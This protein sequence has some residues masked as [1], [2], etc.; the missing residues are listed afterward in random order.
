MASDVNTNWGE[1]YDSAQQQLEQV[2]AQIDQLKQQAASTNE[3]A[4]AAARAEYSQIAA[5]R[6]AERT[7]IQTELSRVRSVQLTL[8]VETIPNTK[9]TRAEVDAAKQAAAADPNNSSLQKKAADLEAKRSAAIAPLLQQLEQATAQ[10]NALEIQRNQIDQKYNAQ[11]TAAS[12]KVEAARA[13]N[14]SQAAQLNSLLSQRAQLEAQ[15]QEA[16][17]R[18]GTQDDGTNPSN[19]NTVSATAVP[20]SATPGDPNVASTTDPSV[21]K[22]V[23]APPVVD[24]QGNPTASSDPSVNTLLK[25]PPIAGVDQANLQA[26]LNQLTANAQANVA[27]ALA[28]PPALG[29]SANIGTAAG[30]AIAQDQAQLQSR[31]DW[32]VR[33]ALADGVKYLY[34]ADNPGILEPLSAKKGTN[35]VIFPYTPTISVAYAAQYDPTNV[36]HSNYTVYQ[37]SYSKVDQVT[38]TCSFTAQD[39]AEAKYMLAVAHFFRSMTKMFYGQDADPLNGT[40]PPLCYLFGMGGWQFDGLP[41]AITG[42][43][44][45]LPE[46]VDYIKTAT[47][48]PPNAPAPPVASKNSSNNRLGNKAE[49]GGTPAKPT[50]PQTPQQTQPI[51][52]VPTRMQ[53]SVSC[54]PMMSRNQTSNYFSLKDYA[55]GKLL[56]GTKRKG[57]AFW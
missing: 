7:P 54:L 49:P 55:N 17:N 48:A 38:I 47:P 3:A 56:E 5:Q 10:V 15:A 43:N 23:D 39:I 31:A 41:L 19:T 57:G 9:P 18:L 28:Q 46:D 29:L 1:V 34:N 22:L 33:L 40:P 20:A 16:F 44:Y 26:G 13:G 2:N 12:Q 4:I 21:Q 53:M 8:Q 11:L 42:F 36:A 27:T 35:G 50:Y 37:Y 25:A 30:T 24:A 14:E 32:R 6:D 52:W 45:S 51:T